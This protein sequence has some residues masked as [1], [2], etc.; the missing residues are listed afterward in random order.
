MS[1][2]PSWRQAMLV[3]EFIE[4][5]SLDQHLSFSHRRNILQPSCLTCASEFNLVLA[6]YLEKPEW[7]W[8]HAVHIPFLNV[9]VLVESVDGS[10]CHMTPTKTATFKACDLK[11]TKPPLR[12]MGFFLG[13]SHQLRRSPNRPRQMVIFSL[14]WLQLPPPFP[15]LQNPQ[16]RSL[17][18]SLD[19]GKAGGHSLLLGGRP[20][21]K[22][23][24]ELQ[25]P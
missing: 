8:H 15:V 14:S 5:G 25:I 23:P 10:I 18:F 1:S 17:G 22:S 16:A 20:P 6:Y 3:Q 21:L 12:N 7:E 19:S 4:E 13:L 2:L 24:V 11:T 9:K